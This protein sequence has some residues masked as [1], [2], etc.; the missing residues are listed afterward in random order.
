MEASSHIKILAPLR[1]VTIRTFRRSFAKAIKEYGFTE[2]ITPFVPAMPGLDPL[3]DREIGGYEENVT[4]Q[5]LGKDPG[6]LK[7]CLERIK[8]IGYKT[9][10]LNCGCPF[11]MVR[12]KGRG[13][14]LLR[15]PKTLEQMIKTGCETMGEG[16]FSVKARIGIDRTDELLGLMPMINGYPLRFLT[17]HPR[18]AKAMYE[19]ECDMDAFR[20]VKDAAKVR[21]LLNGPGGEMSGRP[22]IRQLGARNDIGELLAGYIAASRQELYGDRPVLGR[23]KELI[24]YWREIPYWAKRWEVVKISRSL[25]ELE[26]ALSGR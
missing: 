13:S 19:G 18:T 22:F 12:N 8:G 24:A 21:V 4:V 6:A 14:G 9:A 7:S 17:V 20:R 23:I 2:A 25:P 26:L 5:F 3:K 1:G 16:N 11:P 15:A 10:D